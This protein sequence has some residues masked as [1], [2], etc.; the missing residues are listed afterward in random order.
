[1]A[2]V[3]QEPRTLIPALEPFYA[4]V[5]PL[6][7]PLVRLAIGWNFAVHGWGKVAAGAAA[8]APGF[9]AVGFAHPLPL[10]YVLT[11]LEF[12]GGICVAFGLF[13]RFFAAALAIELAYITFALYWPN[14]F[15]WL[16][17]GY[18]YTLMWGT[19][20]FAIALRGGGP[21]SLDRL[22]RREL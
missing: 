19:L 13:T 8:V 18:E 12:L 9:V 1:M 11:W 20:C 10:I 14:G 3:G 6:A 17:R 7:W 21:Y 16:K 5:A 15:S 22:L 2:E 4:I